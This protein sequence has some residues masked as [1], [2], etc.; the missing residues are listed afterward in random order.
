MPCK[1]RVNANSQEDAKPRAA[2]WRKECHQ[3]PKWCLAFSS[4]N[5][6]SSPI[7]QIVCVPGCPHLQPGAGVLRSVPRSF[8][9]LVWGPAGGHWS[10]LSGCSS[11]FPHSGNPVA[12]RYCVYPAIFSPPCSQDMAMEFSQRPCYRPKSG[13]QNRDCLHV[14]C[15]NAHVETHQRQ[16][17]VSKWPWKQMLQ[18]GLEIRQTNCIKTIK[19]QRR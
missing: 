10:S 12:C 15:L 19:T 1:R 8:P 5:K 2:I 3:V 7:I 13:S 4:L 6:F 14:P 16:K 17:Q 9:L 18:K 11:G